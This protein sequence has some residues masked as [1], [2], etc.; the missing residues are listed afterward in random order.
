MIGQILKALIQMA[1][2]IVLSRLLP[3]SDF[4]LIA[5]V[6]VAV[7][8]GELL[9]D[10]GMTTAGLR[11]R[12]LSHAQAS[13]LFWVSTALGLCATALM[14]ASTPLIIMLNS[15]P[16]LAAL[17][18][19][20]SIT[21]F[22]HGLQAQIQ[23]QLARTYRY[24]ALVATDIASQAIGFALA[25]GGVLL[26]WGY[27]A[28]VAQAVGA[29]L[30]MLI[31]RWVMSSWI[32][33]LPQRGVGSRGLLKSGAN[34]GASQLLNFAAR[35]TDTIM[36]GALWGPAALGLYNRAYQLLTSPV[37]RLLSPL[38]NV[39]VPTINAVRS[40][41]GDVARQYLRIQSVV[42]FGIVAVFAAGAGSAES[43]VPLA[44]GDAW[45][46]SVPLFRTL[47]IG[48]M[49]L[50]LSQVSNWI[51][52]TEGKS[53]ELLKYNLVSKTLTVILVV[54]GSQFSALGAACAYSLALLASWPINVVWLG[55]TAGIDARRFLSNGLR[56]M[57]SGTIAGLSGALTPN[58]WLSPNL[59]LATTTQVFISAAVYLAITSL[60][61]E[62][63][64]M[65]LTAVQAV[66][67][68]MGR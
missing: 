6:A 38:T 23:V 43:L 26:G 52:V 53:R 24:T 12:D 56:I 16:R 63:R 50:G 28:L 18:P 25:V 7:S 59:W 21:L 42:G 33:S 19:A 37:S 29:A 8:L 4:G 68:T 30:S 2:V 48:G 31:L 58:T 60:S 39:V 54:V 35:N 9:R 66:R 62:G 57:T 64:Q 61:I 40:E 45:A 32:P 14:A 5:M 13:N 11:A 36:I 51:F 44:L 17:V 3:P 47:A 65:I 41:G 10:F 20:M 1:S 22:I 34:F 46:A 67:S 15:E 27:W 55:K 49:A